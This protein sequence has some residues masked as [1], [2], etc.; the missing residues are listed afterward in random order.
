MPPSLCF[1][2]AG[3]EG[4]LGYSFLCVWLCLGLVGWLVLL[5]CVF[6]LG[7]GVGSLTVGGVKPFVFFCVWFCPFLAMSPAAVSSQCSVRG[8]WLAWLACVAWLCGLCCS[9][10]CLGLCFGLVGWLVLLSCVFGL[11]LGTDCLT[12]GCV[13]PPGFAWFCPFFANAPQQLLQASWV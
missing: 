4:C 3:C 2:P 10:F 12:V 7:V 5:S 6:G 9:L 11:G 8:A 13:K 1:R